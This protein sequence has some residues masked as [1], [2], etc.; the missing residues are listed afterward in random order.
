MRFYLTQ[1]SFFYW[2]LVN[3]ILATSKVCETVE[4]TRWFMEQMPPA[5]VSTAGKAEVTEQGSHTGQTPRVWLPC[6]QCW[7][8][9]TR[10]GLDK[11]RSGSTVPHTCLLAVPPRAPVKSPCSHLCLL[12]RLLGWPRWFPQGPLSLPALTPSLVGRAMGSH[13]PISCSLQQHLWSSTTKALLQSNTDPAC[14]AVRHLAQSHPD[15]IF[16]VFCCFVLLKRQIHTSS[17]ASYNE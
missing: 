8:G 2:F 13:S 4:S 5:M 14:T 9:R 6:L 7:H 11:K 1:I 16:C 10:Q 17:G 12:P 15:T 3:E